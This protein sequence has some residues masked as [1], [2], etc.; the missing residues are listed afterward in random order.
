MLKEYG[1]IE[2]VCNHYAE[3]VDYYNSLS[4]A[5]KKKERDEKFEKRLIPTKKKNNI[6]RKLFG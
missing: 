3:Y 1:D 6:I 5:D 4:N 2:E